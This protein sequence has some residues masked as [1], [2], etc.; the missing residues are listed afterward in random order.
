MGY[1]TDFSG[2]IDMDDLKEK[3]LKRFNHILRSRFPGWRNEVKIEKTKE[4]L[5][6][7]VFGNWKN[8]HE[9]LEKFA[10]AIVR[11]FPG[12]VQGWIDA[13]GE[14]R[15]DN[16]ALE[17]AKGKVIYVAYEQAIKNKTVLFDSKKGRH[18]D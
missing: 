7:S 11:A 6:I 9:E 5:H 14:D 13:S 2:S 15:D 18:H 17:I 12:H 16:W 8:Y 4:G 3:D 10:M 1:Y